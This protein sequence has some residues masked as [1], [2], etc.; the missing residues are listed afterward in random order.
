[1]GTKVRLNKKCKTPYLLSKKSLFIY[2]YMKK[3]FFVTIFAWRREFSQKTLKTLYILNKKIF[4][5]IKILK[6]N[7]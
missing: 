6:L 5:G 3:T 7:N 4:M 2:H 1:M